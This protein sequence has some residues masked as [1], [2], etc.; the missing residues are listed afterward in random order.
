L[1]AAKRGRYDRRAGCGFRRADVLPQRTTHDMADHEPEGKLTRFEALAAGLAHELRNPLSTIN[2]TLQLLRESLAERPGSRESADLKRVDVVLKELR[3][4]E[5]IVQD[6]VRLAREPSARLR[7]RDMN[8]LIED[9]LNFM[10]SELRAAKIDVVS[11]LDRRLPPISVDDSLFRQALLNLL[12]NAA[13]AMP[14]GGT[15]TVQSH[16]EPDTFALDVIDTGPGMTPEIQ[17]RVFDVFFS[18]KP[19]GTG[20]GLPIVR[21]IVELH[22]GTVTCESAAGHGSR[23]SIRI[24]LRQDAGTESA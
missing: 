21:Q 8:A 14:D 7:P 4:L 15:M 5:R 3:R 2:I 6:F 16:A 1:R 10:A 24:P 19:G 20:V 23:F 22:G 17:E 18:T 9:A 12:R 13:Q 11:Q